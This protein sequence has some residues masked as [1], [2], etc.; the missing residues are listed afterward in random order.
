M[1]YE[2]RVFIVEE[3]DT[4]K[5]SDVIAVVNMCKMGPGFKGIF[6][7]PVSNDFYAPNDGNARVK[8]D[9]YGEKIKAADVQTVINF[10][11]Q[12]VKRGEDYRRI[13]PLLSLLKSFEPAK[14]RNLKVY[15]YGY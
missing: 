8:E 1:G 5:W 15:H 11:E 14:C 3:H 6:T 4:T 13:K 7:Q 2:S 10:L 9:A 12:E